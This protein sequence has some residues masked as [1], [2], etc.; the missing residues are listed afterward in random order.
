MRACF[1][2][3]GVASASLLQAQAAAVTGPQKRFI[4]QVL[5]SSACKAVISRTTRKP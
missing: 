5:G 4:W 2:R 3:E 1:V